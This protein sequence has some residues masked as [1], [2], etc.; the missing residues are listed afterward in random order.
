MLFVD[1]DTAGPNQQP[2]WRMCRKCRI[3]F[4]GPNQGASS[5][6]AGG[7]HDQSGSPTMAVQVDDGT[8][9]SNQQG[10]RWCRNCQGL[11]FSPNP[12][13]PCPVGPGRVHDG[14][15]SAHYDLPFFGVP[16]IGTYTFDGALRA[17]G[18]NYTLGGQVDVFTKSTNGSVHHHERV[19]AIKNPSAPG[20]WIT[21]GTASL[22][23][24]RPVYNGYVQAHD[25]ASNKWSA[26]LPMTIAVRID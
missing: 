21:A 17:Q 16:W 18:S 13:A 6:A 23:P 8:P 3:L 24:G 5:C 1:G 10:W 19:T 9:S 2:G 11:F 12:P 4:Y 14:T 15:P 22:A 25:L 20:G 26:K 7:H